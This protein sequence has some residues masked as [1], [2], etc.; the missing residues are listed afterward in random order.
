MTLT[1]VFFAKISSQ[2]C[3]SVVVDLRARAPGEWIHYY[4]ALTM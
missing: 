4:E 2:H 1:L 3:Q